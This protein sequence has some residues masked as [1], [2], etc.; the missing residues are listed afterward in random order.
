MNR[1]H[2]TAAGVSRA[3]G[4]R[5]GDWVFR[6]V[7][8]ASVVFGLAAVIV[9]SI[10][11]ARESSALG[12]G[13]PAPQFDLEKYGGGRISLADH[14]GK[15][16][17]LDFWATWCAPCRAEMP[18][19]VRLA[20][21]YESRGLVFVAANQGENPQTRKGDVGVF[22]AQTEPALARYVAFAT[23]ETTD[24]YGVVVLPTLYFIDREGRL[25]DSHRGALD[26]AR[27]RRRIEAALK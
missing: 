6:I 25:L 8:G 7:V 21:E 4:G 3:R 17:M 22:I 15:V 18:A 20:Q 5:A 12:E 2:R 27:L 11:E 24:D 23:Q 14:R 26:E 10:E 19:L 1:D 9:A 16:V 13:M